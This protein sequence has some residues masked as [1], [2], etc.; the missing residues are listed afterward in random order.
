MASVSPL[1]TPPGGC[2]SGGSGGGSS[3]SLLGVLLGGG[4][5]VGVAVAR[6][7]GMVARS[8]LCLSGLRTAPSTSPPP[9]QPPRVAPSPCAVADDAAASPR[10]GDGW[11]LVS[12]A[13]AARVMVD[14]ATMT[15][16]ESACPSPLPTRA[17]MQPT[18]PTPLSLGPPAPQALPLLAAPCH[19][20]RARSGYPAAFA[21]A[22]VDGL[23]HSLAVTIERASRLQ[24]APAAGAA[25]VV[26][27]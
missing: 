20:A 16:E 24:V 15:G 18:P 21:R 23:A 27:E 13:T 7:G 25:R 9:T 11:E 4:G 6:W 2:G 5:G 12:S 17:S 19:H 8:P 10:G 22:A 1:R 3:G 26:A 14:A